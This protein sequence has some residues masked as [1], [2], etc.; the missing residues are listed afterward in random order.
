MDRFEHSIMLKTKTALPSFQ[1]HRIAREKLLELLERGLE[2]RLTTLLAPAGYGKTTLLTQ[3]A[4][5]HRSIA[6]WLSLDEMDN[7][8]IR[9]WRYIIF[10]ISGSVHPQLAERME[11]SIKATSH[12]SIYTFIDS[13]LNELSSIDQHVV[14]IL[15]D[16]HTLT[17]DMVH[18]SLSYF[19]EYAP[20]NVHLFIASRSKLPFSTSKW[21][22]R[23][24][25]HLLDATQLLFT[26]EETKSFYLEVH[27][28]PLSS[29]QMDQL[30]TRT[31]GWVAGLQLAAISL[32]NTAQ[33]DQ[34]F[35][36]FTGSHRNI[37]EYLL[38]EVWLRLPLDTQRFLLQTCILSRMDAQVCDALTEQS[39]SQQMLNQLHAQNIF[40]VPLDD[41]Q[42]W[43]RYHHLFSDFLRNQLYQL[44][45]KKSLELHRVASESFARRGLY[46]EAIDHALAATDYQLAAQFLEQHISTLIQ[47]G[48]FATLLR[49]L[50]SFPQPSDMLPPVLSLLHAFILITCGKTNRAKEALIRLDKQCA[51]MEVSEEQLKFFSGLLF[52]KANL[53]F[54]TGDFDSWVASSSQLDQTLPEDPLF[55][56]FNFNTTE[57][58]IRRTSFGL[59][60]MIS[61]QTESV[62]KRFSEIIS[63][64]GWQESLINLYVIQAMAEGYYERNQL[65]DS[66]KLLG[67]VEPASRRERIAGLFVPYSLT[68]AKI[69]LVQG[70]TQAARAII[71]DA[72]DT[73]QHWSASHWL[74]SLR[75][76]L[77]RIAL[78]EGDISQAESELAALPLSFLEQPTIHKELELL[79]YVHLQLQKNQEHEALQILNKLRP[80]AKREGLLTSQ[81]DIAVMQ[82]LALQQLGKKPEALLSLHEALVIGEANQ[83]TRSFIDHGV[84]MSHLLTA[85]KE[86]SKR[87]VNKLTP[88]VSP[89]YVK[90]LLSLCPKKESSK[91]VEIPSPLIEPLT[92]K[93]MLILSMLA[94]GA[95]NKQIAEELR[96]TVGTV[97]VYL[98]RIYGKLG[99]TNR[100]QAVLKAQ[101]IA[102]VEKEILPDH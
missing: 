59:K 14:I 81:V 44:D 5:R 94:Q 73:I 64:Q 79:T 101:D 52:V 15:D 39:N 70:N 102:L 100:T 17:E 46:E 78:Q 1:S 89:A 74:S 19:I 47:L 42:S 69:K 88:I 49:W 43:Y 86:R 77:V 62:G 8:L 45:S 34:F 12:T 11:P 10:S 63:A 76:F 95:S 26:Q 22:L 27:K 68:L 90:K 36:S 21:S 80:A 75:A 85:Y 97:K 87:R 2:G 99:V 65:E 13:L 56:H 40:L 38:H 67:Q 53:A 58:F 29:Q 61:A 51:A 72:L 50:D 25:A 9:F 55:Y 28:L 57:P 35:L 23:H 82:A 83:Y 48:E 93:E 84:A 71:E 54:A 66:L 32:A 4:H 37:S 20:S 96:N 33:P 31:E 60:G 7:D 92:G 24:E 30:Q 6:S 16:Y 91:V 98:H 41:Y 18:A 3:W